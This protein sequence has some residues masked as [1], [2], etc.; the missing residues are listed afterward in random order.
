[1]REYPVSEKPLL[2]RDLLVSGGSHLGLFM[3]RLR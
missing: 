3:D 1:M 2:W